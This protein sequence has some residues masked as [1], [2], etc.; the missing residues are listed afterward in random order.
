MPRV[1]AGSHSDL[2]LRQEASLFRKMIRAEYDRLAAEKETDRYFR[3]LVKYKYAY[4][5][6]KTMTRCKKIL[7][8]SGKYSNIISSGSTHKGVRIINSG[9]GTFA[10]LYALANRS[11]PVYAFESNRRDYDTAVATAGLPANLHY[12]HAVSDSD[13]AAGAEDCDLTIILDGIGSDANTGVT[14][15]TIRIPLKS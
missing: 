11:T 13:F 10:L 2:P 4:R 1:A 12:I 6:W 3:P 8:E 7:R 9:I 15:E 5:G 14:D